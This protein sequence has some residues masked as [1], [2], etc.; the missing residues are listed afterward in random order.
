MTRCIYSLSSYVIVVARYKTSV[1]LRGSRLWFV[2]RRTKIVANDIC[3]ELFCVSLYI[4]F[5]D[6]HNIVL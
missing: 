6:L 3:K 5:G 4:M 2:C 1:Y